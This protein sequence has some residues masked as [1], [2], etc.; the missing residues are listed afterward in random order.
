MGGDRIAGRSSGG[1]DA[2]VRSVGPELLLLGQTTDEARDRVEQ[3]LDNA[4]LAGLASVRL[5][6]GKGTGALR[7][8][9]R[10][11]LAGH[12]LVESFRDGEPS[13]GGTGATVAAL[14]VG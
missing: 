7:K 11:L 9:V 2:P 1:P 14:K 13:E 12:P 8:A 6:H 5:V 10:D 3:Y 4:F